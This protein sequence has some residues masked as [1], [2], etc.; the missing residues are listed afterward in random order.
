M[1]FRTKVLLFIQ[2]LCFNQLFISFLVL[3]N[4]Y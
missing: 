1:Y 2:I 3:K 4:I